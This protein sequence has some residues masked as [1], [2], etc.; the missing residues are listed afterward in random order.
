MDEKGRTVMESAI[1]RKGLKLAK[2]EF[3][4]VEG[5]T[6]YKIES[7]GFKN[8]DGKKRGQVVET[9]CQHES[10]LRELVFVGNRETILPGPCPG[11]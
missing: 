8:I 10:R 7:P 5:H 9:V 11:Y 4:R 6:Y 2:I 3:I 1:N